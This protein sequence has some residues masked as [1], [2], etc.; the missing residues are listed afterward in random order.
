MMDPS[1][2]HVNRPITAVKRQSE[3]ERNLSAA[4]TSDAEKALDGAC[5]NISL[6]TA[7][8]TFKVIILFEITLVFT[9]I[10]KM[11]KP[12]QVFEV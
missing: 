12:M 6:V 5:V 10:L 11:H 4:V 7:T 8:V 2:G 1:R 3:D 9:W